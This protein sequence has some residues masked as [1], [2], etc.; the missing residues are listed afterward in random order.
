MEVAK[1]D[2]AKVRI[3]RVEK[4]P[5]EVLFITLEN[6]GIEV[7]ITNIG[8]SVMSIRTPDKHGVMKNVVAGLRNAADYRINRDYFGCVVG[9]YAN[10]ISDGKFTLQRKTYQLPLNDPPN[11]LHGGVHGF[12]H[13]T[14]TLDRLI[15]EDNAF[16]V[17]F[18]YRSVDGEEGYPGNLD[19][20]VTY[21]LQAAGRLE[22]NYRATTD[23]A[24]P[25]NLT[26]HSYFNL[27]GFET[28]TILD[29]ELKIHAGHY[30]GK[31][32]KNTST[33]KI[34]PVEGTA[35]DFTNF[36]K[37]REGIN[38]FPVDMG[39]DHNF[40]LDPS[41]RG[42]VVPAATLY[43]E[44]SGRI[45]NVYTNKPGVQVYTGNYWDST[46]KGEQGVIYHKHGGLA[47]ETQALP[48][49]V[50]H[51]TFPDTILQPGSVYRSTT[52]FEF[53]TLH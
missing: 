19:V 41:C 46:V 18:S 1:K 3:S 12:S 36:R 32:A 50:N 42:L 16:G 28:D 11:H 44:V 37:I 40:V 23:R 25:V 43:E 49:S 27:S 35:L 26:N 30:T 7:N 10:R 17:A 38:E 5:G 13:K 22:I 45:L 53:L 24:T 15:E 34:L 4:S 21:L 20:T 8:C 52:V 51:S 48:D 6:D 39:Y 9:R 29:H 2:N 33:G 47:L 14:W 31:S